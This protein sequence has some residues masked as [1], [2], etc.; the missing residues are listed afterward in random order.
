MV[1]YDV[2]H[3]RAYATKGKTP[4]HSNWGVTD[5]FSALEADRQAT[6]NWKLP[7]DRLP[8]P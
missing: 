1:S 2:L 5:G 4:R 8:K 7:D 6:L 3:H